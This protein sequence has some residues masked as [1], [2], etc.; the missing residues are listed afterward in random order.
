MIPHSDHRSNIMVREC[1]EEKCQYLQALYAAYLLRLEEGRCSGMGGGSP[2][3]V[4]EYSRAKTGSCKGTKMWNLQSERAAE[5][6][7]GD[8]TC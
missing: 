8:Q 6:M 2:L 3:V 4:K 1:N 5:T 7:N